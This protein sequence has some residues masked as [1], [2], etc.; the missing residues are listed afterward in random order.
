MAQILLVE[1]DNTLGMTLDVSLKALGHVVQWHTTLAEARTFFEEHKPDLVV[2]DL[3]L[4][5]GEGLDL[6]T[7]IRACGSIAPIIILTARD[8]LYA[9]VEGLTAG[10]DDYLTK[11][12]ELPELTARVEAL[13][14]R[15]R[16]HGP[17]EQVTIGCL[18][19]DFQR[20]QAY[21]DDELV[22]MTE[23]EFRLLRYMLDRAGQVVSRQELLTRVWEQAATT[24]TRTV[25]V[26][27]GRLRRYLEVD[28]AKPIILVNVRGV[29]YR[30]RWESTS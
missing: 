23:L 3:G 9:R 10:A 26:F 19:I 18:N 16:W 28:S 7:E 30:L 13:L 12:F 5:D 22:P 2:L 8:S 1:D 17:G 6:C 29:G 21:R 20:L 24:Q 11:P 27:M 4:P 15:Q 14:R 25:D